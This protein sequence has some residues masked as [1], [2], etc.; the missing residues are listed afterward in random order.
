M[1]ADGA[2]LVN[3]EERSLRVVFIAVNQLSLA[4]THIVEAVVGNQI[5]QRADVHH[6]E[7]VLHDVALVV[8]R[9]VR[10]AAH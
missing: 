6:G 4:L 7:L 1:D 5:V 10:V 2:V 8:H 9:E 3:L